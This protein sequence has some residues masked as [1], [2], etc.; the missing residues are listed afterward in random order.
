MKS[1]T[2]ICDFCGEPLPAKKEKDIFGIERLVLQ[3]GKLKH[4]YKGIEVDLH[5][6]GYDCC[7]LCAS[8]IDLNAAN[9]KLKNLAII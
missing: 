4:I 7:E 2:T 5:K 9:F 8:K 1:E 6:Y 3:R